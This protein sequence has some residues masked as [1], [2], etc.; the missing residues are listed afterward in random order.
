MKKTASAIT[1]L[2]VL[3]MSATVV[4]QGQENTS[5]SPQPRAAGSTEQTTMPAASPAPADDAK[6]APATPIDKQKAVL[7]GAVWNPQ[8]DLIVEDALPPSMLSHD[9]PHDVRRF[10]PRFYRMTDAEKRAFWAYFFQALAGAEAGL[11]PTSHVRH[12]HALVPVDGVTHLPLH[13]EG[14]LQL[15][16]E[17]ARRY[18]CDFDWAADKGLPAGDPNRTILQ[19]KN[20]LE[21]GVK[22]LVRQ[23][24]DNR[25]PLFTGRS[26]W[27][28]LRPGTYSYHL[29]ARQMVSPPEA[30][31]YPSRRE[32]I[33]DWVVADTW[34][35]RHTLSAER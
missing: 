27:A 7:G 13:C 14:L 35:F 30:C 17:D 24:I 32:R 28:T 20:N 4:L 3:A 11:N 29:F 8:W 26:Y 23:I 9:L 33:L 15:A 1:V 16:Y 21:C 31:G 2:I 12:K 10:C 34:R 18:G 22:I 5:A 25:E 19:P 6:H